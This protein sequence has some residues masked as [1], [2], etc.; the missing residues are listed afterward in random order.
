[1]WTNSVRVLSGLRNYPY[2]YLRCKNFY[3]GHS[4][5]GL[6]LRN[7]LLVRLIRGDPGPLVFSHEKSFGKVNFPSWMLVYQARRKGYHLGMLFV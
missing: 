3:Y 6:S 5:W 2:E 1:M 7:L 4:P